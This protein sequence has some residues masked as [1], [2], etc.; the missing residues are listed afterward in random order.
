MVK[1]IHGRN[2]HFNGLRYFYEVATVGS[3]RG[4][5]ERL[6]IAASAIN[7]Q[8]QILEDEL[9]CALFERERGRGGVSL[10]AAGKILLGDVRTAMDAVERGCSEIA[11]LHGLRRGHV[12]IGINEGF[13]SAFL[14]KF[15]SDFNRQYP[16][17]TF[18][19]MVGGSRALIDWLADNEVEIALAF[20]PPLRVGIEVLTRIDVET[21]LMMH[22]S[23]PLAS[24]RHVKLAD[25]AGCDIVMPSS[26][27]I[28][29]R[30]IQE[31]LLANRIQ[32]RPIVISNSHTFMQRAAMENLGVRVVSSHPVQDMDWGPEVV[33]RPL[34]DKTVLQEQLICCKK[35]ARELSPAS[36]ILAK[37]LVAALEVRR[38]GKAGAG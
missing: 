37:Q 1:S 32:V 22:K 12:E 34:H 6:H 13:A 14:P 4:A 19:V 10:T 24:K 38:R 18:E 21:K 7:R 20:N 17:I 30:Y 23:H 16:E 26:D 28:A 36:K 33:F 29:H 27:L 2:I 35:E 31:M 11:A 25:L 15:L 3:F 8:V 5:A 9:G